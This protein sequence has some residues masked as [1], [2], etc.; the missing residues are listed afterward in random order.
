MYKQ[1]YYIYG[2]KENLTSYTNIF[3]F[4]YNPWMNIYEYPPEYISKGRIVHAKLG[5]ELF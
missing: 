1:T 3:N 5:I 2:L 4:G